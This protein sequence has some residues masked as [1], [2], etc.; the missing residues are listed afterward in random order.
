MD[1][2]DNLLGVFQTLYRWRKAI[3]NICIVALLGSIGLSLL[4]KNY[5][6]ATT[7]FYPASP[8]L[9]NPELMFGNTG[10][11]TEYFGSDRDLDRLAEVANSSELIDFMIHKFKLFD[12]YGID[13]TAKDGPSKV[14]KRLRKLYN[15]QKN[16]NDAIELSVEDT[17][18]ELAAQMANAARDKINEI[19]RRLTKNSQGQILTAFED[20]IKRK[21]A[22]LV[23]LGDSLKTL[24]RVYGIYDPV[25]QGEQLASSL[26]EAEAGITKGRAKLD[27]L[28]K[29]PEISRDTIAFIR[30]D[31]RASERLR[32]QLKSQNAPD[33]ELTVQRYNEG[34][35]Q[36]SVLKDLHFQARKQLSYD[37]E[38]Y[39]QIKSVYQTDIPALHLIEAAEVPLIKSRPKRS[40]IV[41]ASL[42]AAFLFGAVGA[43]LADNYR[44]IS[45]KSIT[46][47]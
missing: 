39:N 30:A 37:L 25:A 3:R 2:Q 45:W 32:Q 7:I 9:A 14:Q 43:L 10:Q 42:L 47:E 13:S 31:L 28:E 36:V 6:Q 1:K 27:V 12:H 29:I 15:A 21:Q 16:K 11:V 18:P 22:D 24:Q 40:I 19:A 35:P 38:R 44:E 41:L 4:L 20:N 26:A 17:D 34:L 23:V 46:N 33:G 5:Y 8:Q